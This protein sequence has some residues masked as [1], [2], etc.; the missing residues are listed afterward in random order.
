VIWAYRIDDDSACSNVA[1]VTLFGTDQRIYVA[2]ITSINDIGLGF[3]IPTCGERPKH[4][5]GVGDVDVIVHYD[6]V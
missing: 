5:C 3:W 6:G 4:L 1:G 2:A